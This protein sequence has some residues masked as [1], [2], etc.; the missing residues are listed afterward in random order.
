[1]LFVIVTYV[2]GAEVTVTT[3]PTST[4]LYFLLKETTDGVDLYKM[5]F[6]LG[7]VVNVKVEYGVLSVS[8]GLGSEG[9][10]GQIKGMYKYI[11][12]R[13]IKTFFPTIDLNL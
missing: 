1:M 11:S 13:T 5:V 3:T 12:S 10:Q 9:W 7:I 2:N 8:I 4:S 6:L